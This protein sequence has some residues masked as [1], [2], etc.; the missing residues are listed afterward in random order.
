M[1]LS[2]LCFV[3]SCANSVIFLASSLQRSIFEVIIIN[4]TFDKVNFLKKV[5][6]IV[7]QKYNIMGCFHSLSSQLVLFSALSQEES[8]IF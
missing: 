2:F 5:S 3:Y 7:S 8:K 1:V 4:L 6:Q